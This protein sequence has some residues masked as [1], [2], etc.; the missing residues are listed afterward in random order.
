MKENTRKKF[1][2]RL[3]WCL[4]AIVAGVFLLYR[5][6]L[7]LFAMYDNVLGYKILTTGYVLAASGCVLA[8]TLINRGLSVPVPEY[9]DLPD[10]LTYDEKTAVIE[11][12]R[13]RRRR[14]RPLLMFIF[15]F[16][17]T[18]GFEVIELF[19]IPFFR[20]TL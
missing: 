9:D 1:N 18:F 12:V 10:E 8:Y 16:I 6:L 2:W 20:G 3:F 4:L 14:S 15:A 7:A 5:G 17:F 19:T 13:E 11:A